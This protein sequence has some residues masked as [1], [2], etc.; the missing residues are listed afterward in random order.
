MKV[1]IFLIAFLSSTQ[2]F[3]QPIRLCT[4]DWRY[5]NL[6]PN[7]QHIK[8]HINLSKSEDMTYSKGLNYYELDS[9]KKTF[10]HGYLDDDMN[11]LKLE[12][13]IKNFE[14]TNEHIYFEAQTRQFGLVKYLFVK[15]KN[16]GYSIVFECKIKGSKNIML[17]FI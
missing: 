15:N 9:K 2:L 3:A 7:K 6:T 11:F 4:S 8:N 1:F 12:Y 13:T 5:L 17:G 10:I 16:L 14:E